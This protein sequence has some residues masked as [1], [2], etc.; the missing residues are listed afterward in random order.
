[1]E[2][3]FIYSVALFLPDRASGEDLSVFILLCG[4]DTVWDDQHLLSWL[5][6]W[7]QQG[8]RVDWTSLLDRPAAAFFAACSQGRP[9]RLPNWIK[10]TWCLPFTAQPLPEWEER[11]GVLWLWCFCSPQHHGQRQGGSLQLVACCWMER[12]T[13]ALMIVISATVDTRALCWGRSSCV[14]LYPR[15]IL[16]ISVLN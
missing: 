11:G 6:R 4:E 3:F 15:N 7:I 13:A 5:M 16:L 14:R 9:H 1:M 12:H 2:H 8:Q 10:Y